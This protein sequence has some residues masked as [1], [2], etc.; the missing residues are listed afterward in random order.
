MPGV[1][2][3]VGRRRKA[4]APHYGKHYGRVSMITIAWRVKRHLLDLLEHVDLL[5]GATLRLETAEIN[6]NGG[7]PEVIMC[8]GE[9][10]AKDQPVEHRGEILLHVSPMVSAAYD[11]CVLDVI[12]TDEGI[13]FSLASPEAG[14][15]AL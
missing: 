11:G 7:R 13:R 5:E 15:D 12:Q 9:P 14:Q 6:G 8:A 1:S 3:G 4:L 10:G 2:S